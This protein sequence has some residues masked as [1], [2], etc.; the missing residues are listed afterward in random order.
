MAV[1][2]AGG[3]Y[4]LVLVDLGGNSLVQ[5]QV[6]Q[7]FQKLLR[8]DS[9]G[10]QK[11]GTLLGQVHNGGF[12]THPAASA[13]H[14]C[15]D[16]A[17]MIMHNMLSGSCGG[18]S[19]EVGRWSGNRNAG[20]TNNLP[21]EALDF[22]YTVGVVPGLAMMLGCAILLVRLYAHG[23][24]M[25]TAQDRLCRVL[26]VFGALLLLGATEIFPWTWACNLPTPYSTFFM[27]IQYPWRLVGAAVPL[28]SFA[29][30]WGYMR[31]E[32][33][34][35]AGLAAIILLCTV[36]AGYSMQMFV[37]TAPALDKEDF[38][39]TRIDQYEYT[40]VST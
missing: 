16:L 11:P 27:Q 12:H 38:C 39:D 5:H 28:L 31:E 18:F 33:H 35:T 20:Q 40:F 13:V 21:Y 19:G 3:L 9:T 1:L 29:A 17:V 10:P 14:N 4:H 30:A 32:K 8:G 2:H 22:A 37:Q 24:E 7:N 26:L 36:F 15:L 34:R 6:S 23:E 25:Q